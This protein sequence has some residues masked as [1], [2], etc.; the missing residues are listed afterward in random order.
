MASVA[1]SSE[2]R[3]GSGVRQPGGDVHA[4]LPGANQT[5]CGL[6]LSRT[7]LRRFPHVPFDFGTTDVLTAADEI[8]HICPRCLAGAGARRDEP[9]WTRVSPRP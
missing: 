3:D 2:W 9:S 8:G 1:A 7:H 4:W 6:Q 5:M